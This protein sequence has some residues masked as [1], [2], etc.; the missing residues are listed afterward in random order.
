MK[1]HTPANSLGTVCMSLYS[2]HTIC[3]D[4]CYEHYKLMLPIHFAK[5]RTYGAVNFLET[6]RKSSCSSETSYWKIDKNFKRL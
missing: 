5:V 6:R 2:S 3:K 1:T 4:I